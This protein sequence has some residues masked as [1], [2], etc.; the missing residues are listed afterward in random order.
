MTTKQL[1]KNSDLAQLIARIDRLEAEKLVR[2]CMNHYMSFC[3]DLNAGSD[4]SQ[5][6]SMFADGA[7]WRGL[8]SRYANTFGEYKGKTKIRAMF[9]KYTVEPA[10][11]DFNAHFL[12]NELIDVN[13]KTAMGSWMLIQPSTFKTGESRLSCAQ[14]K[15]EFTLLKNHWKMSL[16]T[17]ENLFSRP[18]AEPWD[19]RSSL[20]VPD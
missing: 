11:F 3:D 13:G 2:Q 18:M 1:G 8:G 9:A 16:F 15:A 19:S 14:I 20:D 6:M 10:H 4:L 7:I 5:L 12:C 17:T